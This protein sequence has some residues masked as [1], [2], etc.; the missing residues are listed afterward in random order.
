MGENPP[1]DPFF[2]GMNQN[3]LADFIWSVADTL[4]GDFRQSEF[5]RLTR[6]LPAISAKPHPLADRIATLLRKVAA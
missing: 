6:P 4:R 2:A 1:R 5:G 3:N